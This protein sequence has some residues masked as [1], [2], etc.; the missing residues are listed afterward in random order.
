MKTVEVTMVRIY[1]T[2]GNGKMEQLLKQLHDVEKVRGATVY[3]AVTGFGQSGR[4]HSSTLLD[5]SLDLP[6]VLEFFD[7]PQRAATIQEH[8]ATVIKPGHMVSWPAWVN[9]AH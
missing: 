4:M 9:V 1:I 5:M 3:R 6:L 8:L 7:E 2:E